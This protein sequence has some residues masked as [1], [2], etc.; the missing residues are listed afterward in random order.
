MVDL[1][2]ISIA[3]RLRLRNMNLLKTK[4]GDDCQE[5]SLEPEP[6]VPYDLKPEVPLETEPEVLLVPEPNRVPSEYLAKEHL[7]F[8]FILEI[9]VLEAEFGSIKDYF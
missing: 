1:L 7:C 4:I 8:F 9:M 5:P 6:R 3:G 2:T